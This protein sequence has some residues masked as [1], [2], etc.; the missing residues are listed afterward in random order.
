M[1]KI[2][3]AITGAPSPSKMMQAQQDAIDRQIQAQR[4]MQLEAEQRAE[5]RVKKEEAERTAKAA[6]DLRA[7]MAVAQGR[8]AARFASNARER[9]NEMGVLG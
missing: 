4:Q 1:G 3:R 9:L 2:M 6:E 7:R 8:R 5:E